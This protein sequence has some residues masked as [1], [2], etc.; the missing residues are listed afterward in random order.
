M[1]K[2][3]ENSHISSDYKIFATEKKIIIYFFLIVIAI[4][5]MFNS[6]FYRQYSLNIKQIVIQES[7][8]NVKK[9]VEY[10]DMIFEGMEYTADV[11]QNSQLIQ[12]QVDPG[13]Q[14]QTINH[15][16]NSEIVSTLQSIETNSVKSAAAIDLYL[17]KN[18]RLYTSDYGVYS[19]LSPDDKLYFNKLQQYDKRFVLTDEYRK[20]LTFIKDRNYEQVTLIRPLYIL[21]SGI[22]AGTLA[23]N[24]NKFYL[25]N[26]IKSD[27][28]SGSIIIDSEGNLISSALPENIGYSDSDTYK[29]RALAIGNKGEG[30]QK[31]NGRE[32][33]L[34]YDTSQY[35][36]WKFVN[37][38][39]AN[40]SMKHMSELRDYI[41]LLFLLMNI[42]SAS[43]LIVLMSGKVYRKLKKLIFSMKEVEN[44]NFNINIDHHEKDEFGYMYTSFNN[45]VGRIKTLFGELYQ[46]KLLQKDAELKL[47]QSKI[48]PHFIYNIF[49]NMNW[50]IQLKRYEELEVLVDSVSDYFKKSLNAGRDFI[51]V[52]DTLEQLK[53]YVQIQRVRF[54]NRFFCEFDFDDEIM[55]MLIPNFMLQPLVE[56][57][58]CHGIE[59]KTEESLIQVKGVRILDRVFFTVEDNG[60]GI[61]SRNIQ[62]IISFLESEDAEADNYFALANINKRIKLY[63]GQEYGLTIRSTLG[64]GTKV[65]VI[66]PTDTGNIGEAA[67]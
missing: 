65:T 8:S 1:V 41:L 12:Q 15:R 19:R 63:Y 5:F 17:N 61:D 13:Q 23:I 45:M 60:V 29:I 16:I 21:S 52:S 7:K 3:I 27:S 50:L 42:L 49:D 33:I 56:N 66:I 38:V 37:F 6:L 28:D 62:N 59:P 53:S 39:P 22:K 25:N 9:T 30:L 36:G 58:I 32:F 43:L 31:V 54:R 35:T 24:F 4:F 10:T 34:V 14:E 64:A 26:I 67:L 47:L 46:Q 20:M 44:G 2:N 11:L 57:A 51:S 48:N 40:T 18:G 55:D